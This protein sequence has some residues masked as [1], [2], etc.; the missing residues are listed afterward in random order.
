MCLGVEDI[1]SRAVGQVG[2]ILP[3]NVLN[4]LT[5]KRT[6]FTQFETETVS[7]KTARGLHGL[8]DH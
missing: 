8:Q 1:Q 2:D 3:G 7:L 4:I 6:L 5:A